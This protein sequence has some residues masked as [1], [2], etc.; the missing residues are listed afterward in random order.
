MGRQSARPAPSSL[1]MPTPSGESCVGSSK[2]TATR[3]TRPATAVR[4]SSDFV[5]T[6]ADVVLTDISMEGVDG[7]QFTRALAKEF[8]DVPV[9]AMSGGAVQGAGQAL[10]IAGLLGASAPLAKPFTGDQLLAAVERVRKD[11]SL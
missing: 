7:I 9:I 4:P 10:E 3:W 2:R 5:T 6:P 8:A 11:T 1:T